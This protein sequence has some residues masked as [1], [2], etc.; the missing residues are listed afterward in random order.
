MRRAEHTG[1]D[2]NHWDASSTVFVRARLAVQAAGALHRARSLRAGNPDGSTTLTWLLPAIATGRPPVLTMH[3][4]QTLC[5]GK[6]NLSLSR[7]H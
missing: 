5:Y 4:R 1:S 7:E 2:S 6:A 3:N